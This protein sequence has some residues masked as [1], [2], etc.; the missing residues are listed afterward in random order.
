MN[1]AMTLGAPTLRVRDLRPLL[2]FYVDKLGMTGKRDER[3]GQRRVDLRFVG[4]PE[5]LL[6]LIEDPNA[7]I[8]PPDFAGLYH[9]AALV[10]DRSSLASTLSALVKSKVSFEGFADHQVSESLYL[11]D[12]EHNGI[13]IYADRPRDKWM[14][15]RKISAKVAE[16][17]DLSLMSPMSQP[18]DYQS[19][20]SELKAD[21]RSSPRPFPSGA[22]IGHVHL[23]VTDLRRSVRFYNEVLGLEIM[24]DVPQIG[25]AF[26]SAGGYHHHLGLNTWQSADGAPH[27]ERDAGLDE[28]SVT[29]PDEA[30]LR[31]IQKRAPS[32]ETK[33]GGLL[34][35]D[36]DGIRISITLPRVR[37]A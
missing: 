36:P 11:H 10:P 6:S 32:A 3:Q 27:E 18:L 9:Y 12:A 34:V 29:V 21:S 14:D 15:W 13:E 37:L 35:R 31:E 2:E 7:R 30:T 26:L 20:L 5:P 16:T 28:F 24:M 23:R 25:A 4:H 19:L 33:D 17:G 1:P 8:P 22:R